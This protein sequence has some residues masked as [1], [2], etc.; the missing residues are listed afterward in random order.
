[1]TA[2][3]KAWMWFF[4]SYA[5][6]WIM[7]G[8]RFTNTIARASLIAFGVL[9]ITYVAFIMS[10]SAEERPSNATLTVTGDAGADVSGYLASY[11]L[12]FLTVQHPALRTWSPT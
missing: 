12:P 10:R 4:S 8:L 7:L 9:C 2:D 11:L 6:L 1:M 3:P 5:P